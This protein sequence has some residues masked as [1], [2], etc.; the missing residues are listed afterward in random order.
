MRTHTKVDLD[1]F[2]LGSLQSCCMVIGSIHVAS[3]V[4]LTHAIAICGPLQ[5]PDM[6]QVN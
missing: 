6:L 3:R 4:A 2:C 1:G 5:D